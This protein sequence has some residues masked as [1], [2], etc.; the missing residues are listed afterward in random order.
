MREA[1]HLANVSLYGTLQP[2]FELVIFQS[3][4]I[5]QKM[6]ILNEDEGRLEKQKFYGVPKNLCKKSNKAYSE[7]KHV[8]FHDEKDD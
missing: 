5:A 2:F 4:V 3:K 1:Y 6:K 8:D 7:L